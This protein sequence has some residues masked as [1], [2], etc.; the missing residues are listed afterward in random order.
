MTTTDP[1]TTITIRTSMRQM[2]E[3]MKRPGESYDELIHEVVEEYH[4]PEVVA[5]LKRRRVD[6]RRGGVKPI[7]AA[8]MRR[9]PGI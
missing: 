5:E 7:P 3:R 9:R 1:P 4:P 8:E 2:L 6:V